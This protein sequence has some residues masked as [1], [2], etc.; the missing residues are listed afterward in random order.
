M[1][2]YSSAFGRLQ[3]IHRTMFSQLVDATPYTPS[4]QLSQ[5]QPQPQIPLEMPTPF[6]PSLS[7]WL[8]GGV[9]HADADGQSTA[10]DL[11]CHSARSRKQHIGHHK[12]K[13]SAPADLDTCSSSGSSSS[14]KGSGGRWPTVRRKLLALVHIRSAPRVDM[15]SEELVAV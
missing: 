1:H 7:L 11:L 3:I 15:Q 9:D 14:S 13:D 8:R 2:K 5:S 6:S 12:D 4:A 10:H